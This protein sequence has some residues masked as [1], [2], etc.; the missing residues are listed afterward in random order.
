[1]S[2]FAPELPAGSVMEVRQ[3][4]SD[5]KLTYEYCLTQTVALI[6]KSTA[7]N[8]LGGLSENNRLVDV[9]LRGLHVRK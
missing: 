4:K 1:M 7:W 6:Y 2:A 9:T 8:R 5:P 3:A